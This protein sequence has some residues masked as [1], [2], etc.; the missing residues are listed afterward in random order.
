MTQ[1][2]HHEVVLPDIR[3]WCGPAHMKIKNE[4]SWSVE[5]CKPCIMLVRKSNSLEEIRFY[6]CSK[7]PG[8]LQVI[9]DLNW[10]K[11]YEKL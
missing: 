10:D 9:P 7:Y 4:N 8:C 2:T 1:A 11:I 5:E 6:C 3:K